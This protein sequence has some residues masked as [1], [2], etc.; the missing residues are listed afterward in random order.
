MWRKVLITTVPLLVATGFLFFVGIWSD[1]YSYVKLYGEDT[2][3]W[4]GCKNLLTTYYSGC[5]MHLG[6]DCYCPDP[7]KLTSLMGCFDR[8]GMKEDE[9][10]DYVHKHCHKEEINKAQLRLY[11]GNFHNNS[12][13]VNVTGRLDMGHMTHPQMMRHKYTDDQ[14]L[15][16]DFG[17]YLPDLFVRIYSDKNGNHDKSLLYSIGGLFFWV[18]LCFLAGIANWTVRLFPGIR[19]KFDGPYSRA[20]RKYV[21][22]PALIQRKHCQ[23]Q[24]FWR[25]FDGLV[26]TRFESLIVGIFFI[27]TLITQI[28]YIYHV[29]DNPFWDKKRALAYYIGIR[30]GTPSLIWT[31]LIIIFGGRSNILQWV[32]GWKFSTFVMYHRWIAR[33]VVY[34]AVAHSIV[35]TY[36]EIRRGTYAKD[37]RSDFLIYGTVATIAGSLMLFQGMLFLRRKYYE[38]FLYI[39]IALAALWIMG[40]W[41]HVKWF[42]TTHF[43]IAASCLWIG[44]RVIRFMK[45]GY[46]GFPQALVSLV[47]GDTLKVVVPKSPSMKVTPGGHCWVYFGYGYAFWQNHPFCYFETEDKCNLIFLCKVKRGLTRKIADRL[48]TLP[49]RSCQMRVGIEGCYGEEACVTRHSSVVYMAGGHGFPGIYSEA[50]EE[51]KHSPEKQRIKL[52]WSMRDLRPLLMVWE[53]LRSLA[54]TKIET[55]IYVSKPE[56]SQGAELAFL[57]DD[58]T[59]KWSKES[60]ISLE[61]KEKS[62]N[63]ASTLLVSSSSEKESLDTDLLM[64]KVKAFFPHIRFVEKRPPVDDIIEQELEETTESVAFVTCGHPAMVDDIRAGVVSRIDSTT[65]RIDFFEQLQI[66][67]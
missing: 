21:T 24:G 7:I 52:I 11:L 17:T 65:K 10:V 1:K 16:V 12:V 31:V 13:F 58:D 27:Y 4:T 26:P 20:W 30:T 23:E 60:T 41:V 35:L 3:K 40:S 47:E 46:F 5:G 39:H 22:L 53:E 14:T 63:H 66:W 59:D 19:N 67:T 62:L 51:A 38:A 61:D 43:M 45:M 9:V 57:S 28:A 33:I 29:H 32:T 34:L 36:N 54:Q 2:Y 25:V 55:T 44:D 18:I 8:Y 50:A 56:L 37:M 48:L 15:I 6:D 42:G 64:E 49:D